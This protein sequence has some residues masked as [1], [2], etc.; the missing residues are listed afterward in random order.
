MKV[1]SRI[2][3]CALAIFLLGSALPTR[4]QHKLKD[5]DCLNCHCDSSL[6]TEVNGKAVSLFVDAKM[7]K[8]SIHG[9]MKQRGHASIA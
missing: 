6:T 8:H 9:A 4:A 2:L 3:L 7:L 5:E 1:S